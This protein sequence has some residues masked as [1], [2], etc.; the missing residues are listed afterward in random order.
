MNFFKRIPLF[1]IAILIA[2]LGIH[3]YAATADAYAFPN[4]WFSRDDAYYYFKVAQNISEGH[5]STFDGINV[6][7]GYHP[8]WMLICIPIFALARYDVILPLRLLLMVIAGIQAVTSILIYRLLKQHL[9]IAVAILAAVFWSF[10]TFIHDTVYRLGLETPIAALSIVVLFHFL[11]KIG[12]ETQDLSLK[13]ISQ[14]ALLSALVMF[15]R[16]DLVFLAIIIGA[17]VIFR[18][19]QIQN[20]LPLDM[21]FAFI[22]M[23]SAVILRTGFEAYNSTYASSALEAAVIALAIKIVLFYLFGLYQPPRSFPLWKMLMRIVLALAASAILAGGIYILSTQLGYGATFPRSAFILDLAISLVLVIASRL[24]AIWFTEPGPIPSESPL[25]LF[26]SK[27]KSW[28]REGLTF[29]GILG[30]LL[31]AY[32]VFSHFAFGTTSPVSGQIKRWWGSMGDSAY[33][34][35]ASIWPSYWGVDTGAYNT[36]QPVSE[37][38]WNL[39]PKLKPILPGADMGDERYFVLLTAVSLVALLLFFVTKKDATRAARGLGFIPLIA[40]GGMQTLSYT[41]TAYGGAKE[42]YWVTQMILITL[43][44]SY[45]L[46][47]LLKPITRIEAVKLGSVVAAVFIG[48]ISA[49]S[50]LG[51]VQYTMPHGY[52]P[53]ERPVMEVVGYLEENTPPGSVIGMTGGGNVGYLI[54]DRTIVNMDGLINSYEYFQVLKNGDAATYLYSHGMRIVFANPRLLSLPPYYGQFARYLER[55]NS[56]GGKDLLWLLEEP[57][58]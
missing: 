44:A 7:N 34:K 3:Y 22:S 28:L 25:D 41:A 2:T 33:E 54:K 19:T 47:V 1:E 14:V 16:L 17:W 30:G 56:Y 35:P 40:A 39:S 27:W 43:A 31:I 10:N 29:Y 20:L 51:M 46:D 53:P 58:Y 23:T 42:W 11:S 55:F 24:A 9:S 57:K 5:G 15:S 12:T 45:L 37:T 8:L 6:T 36:W 48:F 26:K 49:Q 13:K 32:M 38:L 52:F 21:L 4:N 50:F 18:G